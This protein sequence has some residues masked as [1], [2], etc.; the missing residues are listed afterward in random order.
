M[1][2]H[3]TLIIQSQEGLLYLCLDGFDETN[4]ETSKLNILL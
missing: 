2:Y 1:D 3:E 4:W